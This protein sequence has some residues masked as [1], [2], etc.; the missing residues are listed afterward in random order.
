MK[1]PFQLMHFFHWAISF[2]R[3][4]SFGF[5]AKNALSVLL[6]QPLQ[7]DSF[8]FSGLTMEVSQNKIRCKT[9]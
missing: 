8:S 5:N 2:F 9:M 3:V 6:L 1:M 7:S 4:S